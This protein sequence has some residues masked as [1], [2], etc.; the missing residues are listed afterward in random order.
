MTQPVTSENQF[1]CPTRD[2]SGGQSG[3]ECDTSTCSPDNHMHDHS[4]IQLDIDDVT[5]ISLS[6]SLSLLL[7]LLLTKSRSRT[8]YQALSRLV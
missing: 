5:G 7:L 3:S 1:L 4:R 8:I 2:H 6:L